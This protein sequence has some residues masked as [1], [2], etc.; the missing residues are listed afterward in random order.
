MNPDDI[1]VR[2]PRVDILE[3]DGNHIIK[4]AAGIFRVHGLDDTHLHSV[5]SA[6]DGRKTAAEVCTSLSS[7]LSPEAALRMIAT[8]TPAVFWTLSASRLAAGTSQQSISEPYAAKLLVVGNGRLAQSLR[9]FFVDGAFASVQL[10]SYWSTV[11]ASTHMPSAQAPDSE[12]PKSDR[13]IPPDHLTLMIRNSEFIVCA[14]EDVAY[15]SAIDCYRSILSSGTACLFIGAEPSGLQLGPTTIPGLTACPVCAQLARYEFHT[16]ASPLR[17]V[18]DLLKKTRLRSAADVVPLSAFEY[19]CAT[20]YAEAKAFVSAPRTPRFVGHCETLSGDLL[21][22]TVAVARSD[23]CDVCGRPREFTAPIHPPLIELGHTAN[24]NAISLRSHFA[25]SVRPVLGSINSVGVVGGGTAGYLAALCLKSVR[26]D[27]S[28]SILESSRIGTLGVGE[29]TQPEIVPFLHRVLG[30]DVY[31]FYENVK[32]T[33]KLG[34]KFRW[35]APGCY[36][37]FFPFD[38]A[39]PIDSSVY[40]GNTDYASLLACLMKQDRVPLIRIDK[41]TVYSLLM[42]YPFAYHIDNRRFVRYLAR[43]AK[44]RDIANVDVEID[45]A[46]PTSDNG[47]IDC[48]IDVEGR[49]WKFD[50]YIDCSGFRSLLLGATLGVGYREYS[51]SLFTDSAIAGTV[52][53]DDVIRPYTTI[54]TMDGG[55]AWNIPQVDEQHVGYVYSS[56]FVSEDAAATELRTRYPAVNVERTFRYRPGRHE[57]FWVG[58]VA[59]FGNAYGF[60]EPLE[61]SSIQLN[62]LHALQFA[63]SLP[64]VGLEHGSRDELNRIVGEDWDGY[65][66]FLAVHYKFNRNRSSPFWNHCHEKVDVGGIV[67]VLQYYD[68]G[69]PEANPL[70]ARRAR[71]RTPYRSSGYM[72]ILCGQQV[73]TRVKLEA[74]QSQRRYRAIRDGYEQLSTRALLQQEAMEFVMRHPEVLFRHVSDD[75]SWVAMMGNR[76][77]EEDARAL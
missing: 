10:I 52:P 65:R 8:L 4:S 46:L 13:H 48:L 12:T 29:S 50:F 71:P 28:V 72:S 5:L 37:F 22:S 55:W 44:E 63:M 40:D 9:R 21:R 23:L 60:V 53:R 19:I 2:A 58:N 15:P 56:D 69:A 54:D 38:S 20:A 31:D 70:G 33:W 62:M 76:L 35:G 27:L 32:P 42:D 41:Q 49:R 43:L 26:P 16:A 74:H 75:R 1:L 47:G 36:E 45:R 7:T 61:A 18:T 68:R 67:D 14:L 66:W 11:K 39:R 25:D 17:R 77:F 59:A 57:R 34:I 64:A 3:T 73:P 51:S 6:V 24:A 30:I